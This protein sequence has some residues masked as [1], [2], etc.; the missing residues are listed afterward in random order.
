[1]GG[2]K[3]KAYRYVFRIFLTALLAAVGVFFN[4]IPELSAQSPDS[5]SVSA[6]SGTESSVS[7]G[8]QSVTEQSVVDSG[9][10]AQTGER[11]ILLEEESAGDSTAGEGPAS[12]LIILRMILILALSALAVYGVVFFIKRISR[13]PEQRDPYIRVLAGAHLGSNR[14]LHV[15]SLGTK[16]WLVGSCDGGVS[17]IAEVEEQEIVDI[18]LLDDSRKS[19]AA[20]GSRFADFKTLLRRLGGNV[21]PDIPADLNADNLRKRRER[22]RG[23]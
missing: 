20:G 9:E 18:M 10:A 22:F 14:F 7:P 19:A 21:P 12:F 1:L 13:S 5:S 8:R 11:L 15:V 23:Q 16:A 2:E 4:N 6:S 3:L 17:L